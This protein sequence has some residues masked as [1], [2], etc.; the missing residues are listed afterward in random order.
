MAAISA[1][2]I[3]KFIFLNE[4][5][6]IEI[7]LKFVARSPIDNKPSFVRVMAWHRIGVKPLP[8]PMMAQFTDAYLRHNG[9]MS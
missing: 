5:D 1:D 3:F 4:N 6:P 8:E 9:E 7:S 2:D